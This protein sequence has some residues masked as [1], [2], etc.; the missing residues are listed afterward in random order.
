MK[1]QT[2][3]VP[4]APAIRGP[5]PHA[6]G[7]VSSVPGAAASGGANIADIANARALILPQV[8]KSGKVQLV[9][10]KSGDRSVLFNDENRSIG[11]F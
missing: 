9:L 3:P 10:H 7:I 8:W 5:T 11:E 6:S 1:P 4:R 2:L